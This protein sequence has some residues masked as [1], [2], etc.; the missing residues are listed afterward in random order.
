MAPVHIDSEIHR[1][2]SSPVLL[3]YPERSWPRVSVVSGGPLRWR[4]GVGNSAQLKPRKALSK[5]HGFILEEG[6]SSI[7]EDIF[8]TVE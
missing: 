1:S 7:R 2:I 6:V 5:I 8:R 4:K 3:I